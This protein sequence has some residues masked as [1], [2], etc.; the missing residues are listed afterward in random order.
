[1]SIS[2][3]LFLNYAKTLA[4]RDILF[5][6][7]EKTLARGDIFIIDFSMEARYKQVCS[8]ISG[9]KAFNRGNLMKCY[10]PCSFAPF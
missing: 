9:N 1:M 4:R 7:Y 6:N 8:T 10:L 3:L 5:L 2:L